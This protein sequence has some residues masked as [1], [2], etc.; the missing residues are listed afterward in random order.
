MDLILPDYCVPPAGSTAQLDSSRYF[1]GVRQPSIRSQMIDH[2][3]QI[4]AEAVFQLIARHAAVR[5]E[6]VELIGAKRVG[7]VPLRDRLVLALSDPGIRG[8]AQAILL[9][10]TKQVAKA[11][12][13][14]AA[15]GSATEQSSEPARENVAEP[16]AEP[17]AERTAK[18]ATADATAGGRNRRWC[19]CNI[20]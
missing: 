14:H 7:E 10:L 19:R 15:G 20:R 11:A 18:P 1:V 16:A 5:G 8:V 6:L 13:D 9:E 12:R 4:L 17:A 2:L 3:R